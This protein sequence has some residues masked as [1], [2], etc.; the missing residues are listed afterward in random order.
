L[1]QQNK[2]KNW[3]HSVNLKESRKESIRRFK[4][5][6]PHLGAYAIRCITAGRVWVGV[7][8]NLNAT[9]NGCWFTL[10]NGSHLEGSLQTEWDSHG[11]SAF[12][13]EILEAIE[14]EIHPMEIDGLLKEK[15]LDW[16]T[17][18][19]AQPLR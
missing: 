14:N 19:G 12:Q 6:K 13:F 18:L 1:C 7:S 17:R 2:A 4:E 16:V 8:R 3:R 5:Q 11:E 9:K 10:R 15:K